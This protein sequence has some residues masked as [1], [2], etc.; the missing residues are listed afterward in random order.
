M[1]RKENV[2]LRLSIPRDLHNGL[3][4]HRVESGLGINRQSIEQLRSS[5]DTPVFI[6]KL[7][8]FFDPT[9]SNVEVSAKGTLLSLTWTT[10]DSRRRII[11]DSETR[12]FLQPLQKL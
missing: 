11:Y 6:K 10:D 4:D 9:A 7:V 8:V 3:K 12:E 5:L 2:W 1:E